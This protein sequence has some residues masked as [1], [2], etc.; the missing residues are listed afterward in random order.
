MIGKE[1][2][3]NKLKY[4][5]NLQRLGYI[6]RIRMLFVWY[7]LNDIEWKWLWWILAA[8]EVCYRTVPRRKIRGEP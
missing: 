3:T 1:K 6:K 5:L 8:K 7:N 4:E 2:N